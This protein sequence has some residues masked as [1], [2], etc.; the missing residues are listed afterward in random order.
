[1]GDKEELLGSAPELRVALVVHASYALRR[2]VT[3]TDPDK[4]EGREGCSRAE[5]E[6]IPREALVATVGG[7]APLDIGRDVVGMF[8]PSNSA[9]GGWMRERGRERRDTRLYMGYWIGSGSVGSIDHGL[10]G[11]I[12]SPGPLCHRKGTVGHGATKHTPE[13]PTII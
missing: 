3:T 11:H 6:R 12:T 5:P 2:R 1:M 7:A 10:W 8:S 4:P 13:S 9:A